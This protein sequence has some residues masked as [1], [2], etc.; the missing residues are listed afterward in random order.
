MR[1]GVGCS[2]YWTPSLELLYAP[3]ADLKS[4]AKKKKKKKTKKEKKKKKKKKK[5]KE[6]KE[7]KIRE[8]DLIRFFYL[9]VFCLLGPHPQHM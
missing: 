6:R 2:S 1:C 3:G 8:W 4:K 5:N 7:K 9:S